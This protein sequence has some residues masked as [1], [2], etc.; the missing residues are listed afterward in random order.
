MSPKAVQSVPAPSGVKTAAGE[1]SGAVEA[2]LG[3]AAKAADW[4]EVS[5]VAA[6]EL[7]RHLAR[8]VDREADPHAARTL[9]AV[10]EALGLTVKGRRDRKPAEEDSPLARLQS[11]ARRQLHPAS[12]NSD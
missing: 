9:L 1:H 7:A 10:L 5:D 3:A 4:L 2:A 6:L 11:A 12:G 8:Q